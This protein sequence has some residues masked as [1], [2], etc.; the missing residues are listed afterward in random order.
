MENINPTLWN[1]G[2]MGKITP[3]IYA[4]VEYLIAHFER[5]EA[6]NKVREKERDELR[7]TIQEL[8]NA[9]AEMSGTITRL[10]Q[11]NIQV[12]PDGIPQDEV[13]HSTEHHRSFKNTIVV[14]DIGSDINRLMTYWSLRNACTKA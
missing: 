2:Q 5:L 12:N 4:K 1:A 9:T 7:K 11:M 10:E 3:E 8:Q 13:V 14:R 6:T